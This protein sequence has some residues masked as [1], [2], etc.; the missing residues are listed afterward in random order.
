[1]YAAPLSARGPSTAAS[2]YPVAQQGQG[3][4]TSM[5]YWYED[6]PATANP[7]PAPGSSPATVSYQP[8][9]Q[10]SGSAPA[11]TRG[12]P[13]SEFRGARSLS[14]PMSTASLPGVGMGLGAGGGI[15]APQAS[16]SGGPC[17]EVVRGSRLV[18]VPITRQVMTPVMQERLV[19]TMRKELVP[20]TEYV[21]A[22]EYVTQDQACVEYEQRPTVRM[23]ETWVRQ[24]VPET[25]Y[26]NIPVQRV[27]QVT[28]PQTV[29]REVVTM[30]EV[31]VPV[32][33]VVQEQCFRIDEV[34]EVAQ[35]EVAVMQEVEWVPRIVAQWEEDGGI[36][37]DY[38]PTAQRTLGYE[39]APSTSGVPQQRSRPTAMGSDRGQLYA[40]PAD[41]GKPR[42]SPFKE[43]RRDRSVPPRSSVPGQY[44]GPSAAYGVPARAPTEAAPPSK[45]QHFRVHLGLS[46]MQVRDHLA[47]KDIA[48]GGLAERAGLQPG[49][50]VVAIDN[51]PVG[52]HEDFQTQI[53][54]KAAFE[55]DV[56]DEG[57]QQYYKRL[58]SSRS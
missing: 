35:R 31:E 8:A 56:F 39:C 14:L 42:V 9:Y 53:R 40:G 4:V 5:R 47:I 24:M 20:T 36:V 16:A 3:R 7:T 38:Q 23:R 49:D 54:G 26:E 30:K 41:A 43:E 15:C 50:L 18:D 32:Q 22:V 19:T 27:R 21:Q 37:S 48:P 17:R 57:S 2:A 52:S 1:M 10:P 12:P 44:S 55:I 45:S 28:V 25:V 33:E 13:G 11:A 34:Q 29:T 58:I 46:L 51:V 6:G